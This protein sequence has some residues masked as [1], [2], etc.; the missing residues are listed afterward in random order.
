MSFATHMQMLTRTFLAYELTGSAV[1]LGFVSASWTIPMLTLGLLGGAIADR[2]DRKVIILASQLGIGV[3][4]LVVGISIITG[5]VTWGHLIIAGLLQG[6]FWTALNPARQAIIPELV[7]AEKLTN[8][9]ALASAGMS[10]TMV[11]APAIGGLA[12]GDHWARRCVLSGCHDARHCYGVYRYCQDGEGRFRTGSDTST[13]RCEV[14]HLIH[15]SEAHVT[16]NPG[17]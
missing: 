5:A 15:R 9:M 3:I 16:D 11:V 8:A 13:Y 1:I 6:F 4:A 7:P 10:L 2:I 14:G 12:Y 17:S